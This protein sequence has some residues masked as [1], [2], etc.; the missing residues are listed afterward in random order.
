MRTFLKIMFAAL[1]ALVAA[2]GFC[3]TGA[4]EKW[5]ANYVSNYV[6]Q[7][8]DTSAQVQRWSENGTNYMVYKGVTMSY[9]DATERALKITEDTAAS[10]AAGVAKGTRFA[11]ADELAGVFVCRGWVVGVT[12]NGPYLVRGTYSNGS[13]EAAGTPFYSRRDGLYTWF[14]DASTQ[15]F[16]RVS[17]TL[18]QKGVESEIL[19][20][21]GQ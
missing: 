5:V 3:G 14:V 18:L 10:R 20:E 16:A 4:T 11:L 15:K 8:V 6:A 7:A 12:T 19:R 21:A 9:E 13:V 1:V 2:R 17:C